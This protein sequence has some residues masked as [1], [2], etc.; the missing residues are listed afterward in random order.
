MSWETMTRREQLAATHYDF[1]KAV[2]G[3]RPRW[4]NYD[5]M[6]EADLDAELELLSQQ[7]E[8]Q[9]RLEQEFQREQIHKFETTV[10]ELLAAGARDRAM[11]IEWLHQAHGTDGDAD[12]L[13]YQL[14]LPYNYL[15]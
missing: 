5:A 10:A 15:G 11:A 6:T 3:T 4:I 2:H 12:Y 13:C 7:A 9:Q 8:E 1:Y 14:G